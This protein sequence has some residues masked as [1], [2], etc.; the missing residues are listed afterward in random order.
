MMQS[1]VTCRVRTRARVRG[2]IIREKERGVTCST[3]RPSK[4]R[5]LLSSASTAMTS[6]PEVVG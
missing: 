1:L 2:Y 4:I 5:F 3:L 6:R